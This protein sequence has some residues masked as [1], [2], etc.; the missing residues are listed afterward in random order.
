MMTLGQMRQLITKHQ[1]KGD[2]TVIYVR[3]CDYGHF[4]QIR[5]FKVIDKN[6]DIVST[7]LIESLKIPFPVI[8]LVIDRPPYNFFC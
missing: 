6:S 1:D 2:N 5:G 3:E 8:E 7:A 4:S